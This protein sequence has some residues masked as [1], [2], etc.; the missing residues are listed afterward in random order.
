MLELSLNALLTL[1]IFCLKIIETG[2]LMLW[3]NFIAYYLHAYYHYSVLL[4]IVHIF[5]QIIVGKRV[6]IVIIIIFSY[7]MMK[8]MAINL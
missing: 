5:I 4:K 8:Y 7:L 3:K 6:Q 1:F 2:E